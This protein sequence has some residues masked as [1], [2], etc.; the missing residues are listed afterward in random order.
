MVRVTSMHG[1]HA[2]ALSMRSDGAASDPPGTFSVG[3][4]VRAGAQSQFRLGDRV[5]FRSAGRLQ[6][7]LRM[8]SHMAARL[9]RGLSYAEACSRVPPM[10][11]AR[12]ALMGI[13]EANSSAKIFVHDAASLVGQ[14]AVEVLRSLGVSNIWVSA[15]NKEDGTWLTESLGIPLARIFPQAWLENQDPMF[16]PS[17]WGCLK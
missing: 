5:C 2:D 10:L 7:H 6:S 14:A 17:G 4:V 11:A 12:K 9:P 16:V 1:C 13:V 15:V 3:F 8:P